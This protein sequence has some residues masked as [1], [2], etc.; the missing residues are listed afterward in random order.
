MIPVSETACTL[1]SSFSHP[2]HAVFSKLILYAADNRQT[3]L[4]KLGYHPGIS[5]QTDLDNHKDN[6]P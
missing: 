4:N 2:F 1:M 6:F 3:S 5:Q